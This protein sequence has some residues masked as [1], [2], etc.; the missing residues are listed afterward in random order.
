MANGKIVKYKRSYKITIEGKTDTKHPED[1]P[2]YLEIFDRMLKEVAY[3]MNGMT[4]WNNVTIK[5]VKR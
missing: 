5:E 3:R 4:A 1:E 2:L